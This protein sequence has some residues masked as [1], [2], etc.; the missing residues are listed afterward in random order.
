MTKSNP[1]H[2][3]KP[4]SQSCNCANP[5]EP[6]AREKHKTWQLAHDGNIRDAM[7]A[8]G[9]DVVFLGD[10]I[11]EGWRGMSFGLPVASKRPNAA[12][13]DTLFS[14]RRGADF[15]GLA[16][17]I[18]GDKTSNLLWRMQNNEIPDT[19]HPSIWWIEIG[20][21]DFLR[22]NYCSPEVV[23][24]GIKRVVE[25]MRKQRPGSFIVVNSLLPRSDADD[26][27][28]LNS[29]GKISVW[30]GILEVN[31]GLR[32]YCETF[33]NVV[34]FDATSIFLRQK[35]KTVGVDGQY[36]PQSLMADYLHPTAEGYKKWGDEIVASI[37]KL[38]DASQSDKG[39]IPLPP[40]WKGESKREDS[41][42]DVPKMTTTTSTTRGGPR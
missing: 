22:D 12:V 7:N 17:G 27:S 42:N 26:G 39:R 18:A 30:Q 19:L 31:R 2:S 15:Q 29:N 13:F 6:K 24:M 1:V 5:L 10:S 8:F 21:N 3:K 41:N 36:I 37:H 28:L 38:M 34:Y 33:R 11:I 25:E 23:L 35:P 20:T 32:N 4:S 14:E 16:L 40:W 9:V